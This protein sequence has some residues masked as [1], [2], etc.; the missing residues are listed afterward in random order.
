[1]TSES[2]Q[3]LLSRLRKENRKLKK[4]LRR[5]RKIEASFRY[6]IEYCSMYEVKHTPQ[7][8]QGFWLML[9]PAESPNSHLALDALI[10]REG[11]GA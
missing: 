4:Q 9:L 8:N 1:M 11:L 5:G 6:M 7:G 10:A 3:S 2:S